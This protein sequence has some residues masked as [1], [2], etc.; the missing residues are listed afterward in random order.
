MNFPY[1]CPGPHTLTISATGNNQTVTKTQNVTSTGSPSG[2]PEV[3]H[4][5]RPST[6]TC[7]GTKPYRRL[8][9]YETKNATTVDPR[10]TARPSAHRQA[11]TRT[12]AR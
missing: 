11:T 12:V 3:D 8:L 10:S 5:Q 6:V 7:M 2:K 9:R 1:V 4:L